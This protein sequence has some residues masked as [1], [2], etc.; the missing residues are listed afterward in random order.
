[1]LYEDPLST[2]TPANENALKA[3]KAL[4]EAASTPPG[5]KWT[6]SPD[7]RQVLSPTKAES[8]PSQPEQPASVEQPEATSPEQKT[9]LREPMHAALEGI[10][11]FSSTLIKNL[12]ELDAKSTNKLNL[13][14]RTEWTKVEENSSKARDNRTPDA[15]SPGRLPEKLLDN[16][17]TA[18]E[19]NIQFLEGLLTKIAATDKASTILDSAQIDK[20]TELTVAANEVLDQIAEAK[21]QPIEAEKIDASIQP[22]V[23]AQPEA[24][25]QP[26]ADTTPEAPFQPLIDLPLPSTDRPSQ[27]QNADQPLPAD[28]FSPLDP[29]PPAAEIV[30]PSRPTNSNVEP[31]PPPQ[32]NASQEQTPPAPPPATDPPQSNDQPSNK[33][34]TQPEI[35]TPDDQTP[36]APPPAMELPRSTDQPTNPPTEKNSAQPLAD[37]PP[38]PP[39]PGNLSPDQPLTPP[40]GG[41]LAV[42]ENAKKALT[43][44]PS[45][46]FDQQKTPAIAKNIEEIQIPNDAIYQKENTHV[47]L[48]T[49]KLAKYPEGQIIVGF[50]KGGDQVLINCNNLYVK[51]KDTEEIKKLGIVDKDGQPGKTGWYLKEPGQNGGPDRWRKMPHE[52]Y[53]LDEKT[54]AFIS[55]KEKDHVMYFSEERSRF[56]VKKTALDATVRVGVDN[57]S[58]TLQFAERIAT[59]TDSNAQS[60][61]TEIKY[62][63]PADNKADQQRILSSFTSTAFHPSSDGTLIQ[64]A[65]PVSF[66]GNSAEGFKPAG[67]DDSKLLLNVKFYPNGNTSYETKESQTKGEMVVLLSDGVTKLITKSDRPET[68]DQNVDRPQFVFDDLGRITRKIPSP[69]EIAKGDHIRDF[70]YI[71][72][73]RDLSSVTVHGSTSD[74]TWPRD[75]FGQP[76]VFVYQRQGDAA[77]WSKSAYGYVA[78]ND[79]QGQPVQQWAAFNDQYNNPWTQPPQGNRTVSLTGDYTCP[80]LVVQK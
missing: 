19:S 4:R 30:Q 36:P 67:A 25:V 8:K 1:M 54:G 10:H 17:S 2:T 71:G 18:L 33:T 5:F 27:P 39:P 48:A 73:S 47:E 28:V 45:T 52:N 16:Y 29:N 24:P 74:I 68:K 34:A 40:P 80:E 20:A 21:K 69:S 50:D 63:P 72:H 6:L 59:P 49:M 9:S 58:G 23:N 70:T 79:A 38:A 62:Q 35:K 46:V 26:S 65:P 53:I 57:A 55:Q 7:G 11:G 43:E 44:F 64:S 41:E 60:R 77:T 3:N 66:V 22:P 13:V 32:V 78:A 61:V 51:L 42:S 37:A 76:L 31:T 56:D 12:E 75:Q 15:T 14:D